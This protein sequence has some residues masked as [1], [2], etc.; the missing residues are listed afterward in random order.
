MYNVCMYVYVTVCVCVGGGMKNEKLNLKG[1]ME[2][3]M[4]MKRKREH[5][6]SKKYT[7]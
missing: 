1:G 5:I 4:N 7:L 6:T 3:T 2:K